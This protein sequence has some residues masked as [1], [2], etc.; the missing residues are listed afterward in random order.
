[1]LVLAANLSFCGARVNVFIESR[2]RIA[3]AMQVESVRKFVAD[4]GRLN[5][6]AYVQPT[7]TE[8]DLQSLVA[9][10]PH[11]EPG[12]FLSNGV[13]A[14]SQV[15]PFNGIARL[16]ASFRP[17]VL[18]WTDKSLITYF[19]NRESPFSCGFQVLQQEIVSSECGRLRAVGDRFVTA[20]S[21]LGF[22]PEADRKC[23]EHL[24][25][26][27]GW[28]GQKPCLAGT[29]LKKLLSSPPFWISDNG[30]CGCS[31]RSKQMD[32]WGCDECERREDQIVG[33]LREEAGNRG[34]PFINAA[35]RALVRMAI[36]RA[37]RNQGGARGGSA[38]ES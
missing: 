27:K 12:V 22:P 17:I 16:A 5:I 18:A 37:R 7:F 14:V 2:N 13:V 1:M 38:H 25:S 10:S 15:G 28:K 6:T 11:G 31:G 30:G 29:E 3:S 34:L 20:N 36:A 21:S 35:G 23:W 26:I 4:D 32:A 8:A 9:S 33:W 24:T 19:D